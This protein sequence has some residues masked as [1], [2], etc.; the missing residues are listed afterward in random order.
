MD[1]S[2]E[3]DGWVP[4]YTNSKE[5]LRLGFWAWDDIEENQ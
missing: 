3:K 1:G 4:F 5:G 2:S